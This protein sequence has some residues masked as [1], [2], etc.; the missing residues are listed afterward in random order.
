MY[1]FVKYLAILPLL[2]LNSGVFAEFTEDDVKK[3]VLS[4]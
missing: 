3:F 4:L 2:A 1:K